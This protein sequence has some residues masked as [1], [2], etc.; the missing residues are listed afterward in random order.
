MLI[1]NFTWKQ[2]EL[3]TVVLIFHWC[4]S[5]AAPKLAIANLYWKGWILLAIVASL[6]PSTIGKVNVLDLHKYSDQFTCNYSSF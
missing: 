2:I 4:Y 1:L 3:I 6:N 5:Y